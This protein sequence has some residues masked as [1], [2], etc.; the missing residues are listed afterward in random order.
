[1]SSLYTR[2]SL[3]STSV[4]F[5]LKTILFVQFCHSKVEVK[6]SSL[7]LLHIFITFLTTLCQNNY[8]SNL[9]NCIYLTYSSH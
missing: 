5:Y 2:V 1:M 3:I 9:W 8:F 7:Q 4:D 6:K